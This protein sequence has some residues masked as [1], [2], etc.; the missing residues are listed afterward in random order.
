[1]R[2]MR[3]VNLILATATVVAGL[4]S[5]IMGYVSSFQK[6]IA[7]IYVMYALAA[8]CVGLSACGLMEY[9]ALPCLQHVRSALAAV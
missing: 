7:G 5:W 2:V 3:T 8:V 9:P 6:V 1:M 4:L